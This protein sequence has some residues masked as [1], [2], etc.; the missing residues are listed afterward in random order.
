MSDQTTS[1]WH[2]LQETGIVQG[3]PP[4]EPE[5]P[6]PWYVK[7]LLGFSGWLAAVFLLATLGAAFNFLFSQHLATGI[8]GIGLIAAAYALLRGSRNDFVEQLALAASLAGQALF[9]WM[10]FRLFEHHTAAGWSLLA[11][12][13]LVLAWLMP[14]FIHRVF[15]SILTALAFYLSL[16]VIGATY[17]FSG[18]TSLIAAWLW[19][20]EF[21]FP[22]YMPRLRAM[23]YGLVLALIPLKGSLLYGSH[24]G[25]S[26]AYYHHSALWLPPWLGEALLAIALLYVVWRILRR[27]QPAPVTSVIV[28][29]VV[30]S[31]VLSAVSFQAHGLTLGLMIILLGFANGNRVLQGLGIV[32]LLF[33]IS[34]YYYLLD[35]TLLNKSLTLLLVGTVLLIARWLLLRVL[36]RTTEIS[37]GR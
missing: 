31:L 33:F 23:G 10:L 17:L 11:V 19:L 2:H 20:N 26:A 32:A 16:D 13:E 6:T 7:A 4:A 27:Q 9:A 21:R 34:S 8:V 36:V 22:A 28:A 5:L 12:I 24:L 37:D 3:P 35:T 1:L 14:H 25:W 18:V 15:S 29:A 30:S